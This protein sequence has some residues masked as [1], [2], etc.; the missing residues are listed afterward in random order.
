MRI[1]WLSHLVPYPPKGGVLQRS[2]HLLKQIS[3]EFNVDLLAFH[4]PKLMSPIFLDV[5]KGLE[6]SQTELSKFCSHIEVVNIPAETSTFNMSILTLKS[7]VTREPYNI[8][9]L[10][11]VSF[12]SSMPTNIAH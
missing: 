1:L 5:D 9:G 6:I 3:K 4:Q 12:A 11:S 7:L 10:K 2:Y 8:N